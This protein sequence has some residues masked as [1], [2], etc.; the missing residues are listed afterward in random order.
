MTSM[1]EQ[2]Q[3][4]AVIYGYKVFQLAHDRKTLVAT[5][6]A[7]NPQ[8]ST[9]ARMVGACIDEEYSDIACW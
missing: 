8:K 3:Q 9:A 4:Y 7:L 2:A 1:L 5:L 6:G